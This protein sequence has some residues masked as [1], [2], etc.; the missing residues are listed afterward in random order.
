M[1]FVVKP[2]LLPQALVPAPLVLAHDKPVVGIDG[3]ILSSSVRSLET[4]LLQRHRPVGASPRPRVAIVE[5][6]AVLVVLIE[7]VRG[8]PP[9]T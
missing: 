7:A 2:S 9:P 4:R 3:V 5:T 1:E 8:R 6:N